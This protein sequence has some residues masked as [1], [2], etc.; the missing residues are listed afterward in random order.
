MVWQRQSICVLSM[1]VTAVCGF[2]QTPDETELQTLPTFVNG[3]AAYIYGYPLLMFGTTEKV[4][5]TVPDATTTL[6]GAPLNQFGKETSLPNSSFT[7]VVLPSTTTTLCLGVHQFE[8]GTGNPAYSE[9]YRP[10]F[11]CCRCWMGGPM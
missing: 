8:S 6:G 4:A 10:F 11:S 1:V 3:L 5:I 7:D 2:A 9:H